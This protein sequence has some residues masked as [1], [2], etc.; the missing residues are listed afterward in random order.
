[1]PNP[2]HGELLKATGLIA[3]YSGKEVLS[4]VNINILAGELVAVIGHNGAGKST[5][6]KALFGLIDLSSGQV[7]MAEGAW[8]PHPAHLLRMGVAYVPQGNVVFPTLTVLENL[9]VA[10]VIAGSDSVPESLENALAV[11]P[12]LRPRLGQLA[13]TLSGGERQM[14]ALGRALVFRPRLLLLDEPSLGLSPR[15]VTKVFDLVLRL[16][17]SASIAVVLVEQKVREALRISSRVYAL[18]R[19]VVVF[20]GAASEL[21]ENRE[22]LRG[23]YL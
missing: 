3:G 20:E 4:G 16:V 10:S 15:L 8:R 21:L 1:M 6:L 17:E 12:A 7:T 9:R 23:S 5:L 19:G 14:L 2:N 11:F 22:L 18:K 13:G